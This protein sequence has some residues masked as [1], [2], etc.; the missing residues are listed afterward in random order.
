MRVGSVFA[1]DP[2]KYQDGLLIDSVG[3]LPRGALNF[4]TINQAVFA[5]IH[6]PVS[7][8]R[9]ADA[10][11]TRIASAGQGSASSQ[12]ALRTPLAGPPA[13]AAHTTRAALDELEK[14]SEAPMVIGK[15]SVTLQSAME[16]RS[17]STEANTQTNTGSG[18]YANHQVRMAWVPPWRPAL[19][20]GAVAFLAQAALAR[21]SFETLG[22]TDSWDARMLATWK[23]SAS[24]WAFGLESGFRQDRLSITP[25]LPSAFSTLSRYAYL[26]ARIQSPWARL[27]VFKS[28]FSSTQD[29]ADFRGTQVSSS[30]L[31]MVLSREIYQ[32]K[33]ASGAGLGFGAFTGLGLVSQ[34][35]SGAALSR[36][37]TPNPEHRYLNW[38][39]GI[40]LSLSMDR[41]GGGERRS[42]V[43]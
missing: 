17:V 34:A 43:D 27:E 36:V 14:D 10:K 30:W 4:V 13:L 20:G 28:V 6:T 1:G 26:G 22:S 3:R 24:R 42:D 19:R 7:N 40:S 5:Q 32:R 25:E 11:E 12:N 21:S 31:A 35:G 29:S 39:G 16:T 8:A 37:L 38:S 2:K 23:K 15:F 33:F 18:L 9:G 41:G